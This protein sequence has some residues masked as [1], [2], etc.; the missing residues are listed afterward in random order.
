MLRRARS[1][2]VALVA[3]SMIAIATTAVAASAEITLPEFKHAETATLTFGK[4]TIAIEGGAS[5][6]CEKGTG[7]L[8]FSAAS[9]NLG[10]YTIAF[11]ECT[12]GGEECH[13]L[14]DKEGVILTTGEWHLVLE[15]TET[16]HLWLVDFLL[17]TIDEHLECPKAIIKLFLLLGSLLGL[18]EPGAGKAAKEFKLI[19]KAPKGVQVEKAYE[20]NK[21]ELVTDIIEVSQEGGKQKKAGFESEG[22]LLTFPKENEI[23]SPPGEMVLPEFKNAEAATLTFGKNLISAEGGAVSSKCEKGTGELGFSAS[24]HNLGTYTLDFHEC[25]QS[26]EECHSLSDKEGAM[27]L[28]G[29][30]HL[31]LE[32]IEGRFIWLL[33]FLL[34]TPDLH[35]ECPGALVKLMLLLGSLLGLLEPGAGKTA[36]EFKLVLEAPKGVQKQ[37]TY[38][39]NK[40]ERVTDVVELSQE[41]GKQKN[42]GFEAEAGVLKFSAENEIKD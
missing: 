9:H 39:N 38:E 28:T 23:V 37:K 30:W 4:G 10:T 15:R 8:A 2:F 33:D 7:E 24:S 6:K 1:T 29:E 31:V 41:G 13:S 40:S 17:P 20:N 26:G 14:T 42:A 27:L 5:A 35:L 11:H 25:T 34:P 19:L 32:T 12:E 36:K 3:V 21:G 18:L 16:S 22:D